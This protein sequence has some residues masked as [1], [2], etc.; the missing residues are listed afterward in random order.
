[1]VTSVCLFISLGLNLWQ[2]SGNFPLGNAHSTTFQMFH[3][4]MSNPSNFPTGS[5]KVSQKKSV[6]LTDGFLLPWHSPWQAPAM[7]VIWGGQG[8]LPPLKLPGFLLCTQATESP[9]D[10]SLLCSSSSFQTTGHMAEILAVGQLR[11]FLQKLYPNIAFQRE[12]FICCS[13]GLLKWVTVGNYLAVVFRMV[14][15]FWTET[16]CWLQW[17]KSWVLASIFCTLV[18]QL[19]TSLWSWSDQGKVTCLVV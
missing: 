19:F 4:N 5:K 2:L 7:L 14:R 6:W 1:M 15:A 17:G 3:Q 12:I 11:F 13:G 18:R 9:E 10:L 16:L 8:K